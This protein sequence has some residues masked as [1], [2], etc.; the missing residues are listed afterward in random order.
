MRSLSEPTL[1]YLKRMSKKGGHV[2][3][4]IADFLTA[5]AVP[6]SLRKQSHLVLR[7]WGSTEYLVICGELVIGQGISQKAGKEESYDEFRSTA[8]KSVLWIKRFLIG[9]KNGHFLVLS[10]SVS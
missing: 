4:D 10:R 5:K 7:S 9:M 2:E 6:L 3:Y 8:Y 1:P